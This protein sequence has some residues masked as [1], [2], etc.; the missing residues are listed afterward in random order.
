MTDFIRCA[1]YSFSHGSKA[2]LKGIDFS[3]GRGEALYLL[4]PNGSG[5]S[6][7]LR[8]LMGLCRRRQEQGAIL[9]D[10]KYRWLYSLPELATLA[11]YL[12]QPGYPVP[13]FTVMEFILLGF[14]SQVKLGMRF[15]GREAAY[16]A[17]EAVNLTNYANI[18]LAQLSGGQRQRA[19]LAGALARKTPILLLDEP[20]SFLDPAHILSLCEIIE[21]VVRENHG[22]V[23]MATHNLSIPFQ[24][25][26]NILLLK[27]GK[28]MFFGPSAELSKNPRILKEAFGCEFHFVN[29]PATGRAIAFI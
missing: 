21:K 27:E 23:I 18:Q 10:G 6:T 1:D 12:P 4:G 8:S 19:Y 7:L 3:L 20:D 9:L 14:F 26:G 5:K 11:A 28:K 25:G 24:N 2:I 15:S 16:E 17:L 22:S 13:P 29:H